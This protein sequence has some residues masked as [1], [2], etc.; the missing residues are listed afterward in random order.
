[1]TPDTTPLLTA[2]QGG[3]LTL[4]ALLRAIAPVYAE[5]GEHL[6]TNIKET[7]ARYI[8]EHP[9]FLR[10]PIQ[11]A[12]D[13]LHTLERDQIKKTLQKFLTP[14]VTTSTAQDPNTLYADATEDE[15]VAAVRAGKMCQ[16]DTVA[17][18]INMVHHMTADTVDDHA[19]RF[20]NMSAADK[21]AYNK[22]RRDALPIDTITDSLYQM[23][24]K[25]TPEN[26]R[27]MLEALQ[28][29]PEIEKHFDGFFLHLG[30]FST[31]LL[32]AVTQKNSLI[33][34]DT[35]TGY[36]LAADIKFLMTA[37]E[38]A[39]ATAGMTPDTPLL[40]QIEAHTAANRAIRLIHIGGDKPLR[41]PQMKR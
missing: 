5:A 24:Q 4:K 8:N 39:L 2:L 18:T 26:L 37:F 22:L 34:T 10:L 7:A 25:A 35:T 31:Q 14:A 6:L 38:K 9:V 28:A 23:T 32:E 16:S 33:P 36:K 12:S 30:Q 27:A 19:R 13:Y 3:T 21:H 15:F 11:D 17:A 29:T 1:M 40:P 41:L 20:F